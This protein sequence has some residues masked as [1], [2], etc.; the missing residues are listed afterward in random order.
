M[1]RSMCRGQAVIALPRGEAE[2]YGLVSAASEALGEQS[3]AMDLG[4]KLD[5]KILMDAGAGVA[6]GSRRGVGK[7]K[8]KHI[9]ILWVQE[10]VISGRLKIKKVHT[11]QNL[12]DV[13][14]KPVEGP[15]LAAAMS[16]LH[17]SC[18]LRVVRRW[19]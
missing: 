1:L 3:I 16:A 8:H 10:H 4:I 7:V 17:L 15:K 13:L 6:I 2:F 14:T 11:S 9:A 5:I 12:S 18:F 19:L